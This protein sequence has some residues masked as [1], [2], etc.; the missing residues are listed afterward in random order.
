MDG[1]EYQIQTREAL[2]TRWRCRWHHHRHHCKAFLYTIGDTIYYY[3]NHNHF[4]EYIDCSNLAGRI[5]KAVPYKKHM[6]LPKGEKYEQ[7]L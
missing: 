3:S 6:A 1:Y 2:K 5:V 7:N 4:S